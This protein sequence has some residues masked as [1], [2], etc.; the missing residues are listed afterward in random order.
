[1]HELAPLTETTSFLSFK[2]EENVRRA[3]P[4]LHINPAFLAEFH[5]EPHQIIAEVTHDHRDGFTVFKHLV[6]FSQQGSQRRDRRASSPKPMLCRRQNS[7]LLQE[8]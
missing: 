4:A 5:A 1:M 8:F 6:D 7:L 2:Y 3:T